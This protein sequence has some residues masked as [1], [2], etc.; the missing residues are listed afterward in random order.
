MK[1]LRIALLSLVLLFSASAPAQSSAGKAPPYRFIILVDSSYSM[2]RLDEITPTLVYDLIVDGIYGRMQS[3]DVYAVWSFDEEVDTA[4]SPPLVWRPELAKSQAQAIDQQIRKIK[5]KGKPKLE[6]AISKLTPIASQSDDLTIFILHDGSGVM[7]GTPFDLKITAI[8]KQFYKDMAKNER[9]FITGL[10]VQNKK[11]VAWSVDAAGGAPTIPNFPRK[12]RPGEAPATNTVAKASKPK[13]APKPAPAP[14]PKKVVPSIIVKGPL[15][16][17]P[18]TTNAPVVTATKPPAPKTTPQPAPA[19]QPKATPVATPEPKAELSQSATTKMTVPTD[20]TPNTPSA[21]TA[22]ASAPASIPSAIPAATLSEPAFS[23]TPSQPTEVVKATDIVPLPQEPETKPAR[24]AIAKAVAVPAPVETAPAK[25][26]APAAVAAVKAVD[27]AA[28]L[29][30]TAV[31]VPPA[32]GPDW[33]KL[34]LGVICFIAA[35][36]AV[37]FLGRRRQAP[38]HGSVISRSM[39]QDK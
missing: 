19:M 5:Y 10:A 26:T 37:F 12:S 28:E 18:K 6:A 20:P 35:I 13:E 22:T 21:S 38:V 8:Y 36:I 34:S 14:E 29:A 3:G 27:T 1:L 31:V 25:P 39:N 24:P 4:F 7:Y 30:Q 17:Q 2:R 32:G 33:L 23:I 11:M 9:P 15:K 16:P